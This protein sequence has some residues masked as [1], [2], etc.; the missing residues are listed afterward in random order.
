M[1]W[2]RNDCIKYYDDENLMAIIPSAKYDSSTTGECGICHYLG[3]TIINEA[4]C[5]CAIKCT[6]AMEEA[7]FNRKKTLFTRKMDLHFR[8]KLVKYYSWGIALYGAVTWD[9]LERR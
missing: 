2:N 3:S 5:T 7:T 1:L 8:K 4:R 6:I 9:T